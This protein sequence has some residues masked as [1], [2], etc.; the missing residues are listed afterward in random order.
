MTDDKVKN[1]EK[2]ICLPWKNKVN[3]V[4]LNTALISDGKRNHSEIIDIN[5]L[6]GLEVN[7][8]LPTIV[9]GHHDFNSIC[10]SHRKR[11]ISIFERL[12]VKAY[13]CGDTHKEDIKSIEKYD[14]ISE[15]IPCIICGKSAVQTGDA[16]SDV[17]IIEYTWEDDGYVYVRPYRWGEKY[18]FIKADDFIYDIDKDYRFLMSE[19][20]A[21]I[22]AGEGCAQAD[23]LGKKGLSVTNTYSDITEA[24]K[25]IAADIKEGGFFSFYGLRGATFIGTSEVNAIVK[26][27]K[28]NPKLQVKFLISY[29]FSEE[30]RHRLK[31]IPKFADSAS[32]E[33]KWRD[34]YKKVR[35][36]RQEYKAYDNVSVRFHDTS[37]IFRLMF[38]RKHL[39]LGYY[40]PGKDS[41]NTEIYQFDC[42]SPTYKTY[43]AFFDYQWRK[44]RHD[45]PGRIPS[46]YSFLQEKFSV[47]PSLVINVT[48]SCN[49]NCIYC[50]TGGENLQEF[51]E[52]ECLQ[53]DILR[54]LITAFKKHVIKDKGDPIL[55]ITGGEPLLGKANREKTA[56]ILNAAKDFKKIVL[57]TNAIYLREAYEEYQKDWD[58]V[59]SKLLLKISLDTLKP[60]RFCEITRTGERGKELFQTL[61]DNI[62][63]ISDKGFKIELNLVA[64]KNNLKCPEDLI[65]V[66]EFAQELGLV[67]VKILTVNDFGGNVKVEQGKEEQKYISGVLADVIR[68]MQEREYEEKEVYLN[69]DKGIQMRRFIAVSERDK[70]CTL[71]IVD[72]HNSSSSI[73]PRR[74]FS[75]FCDSCKYFLTSEEVRKGNVQPCAT[76]MMSLTVR[77]D[78]VLSPCRL[79]QEKGRNIK[80]I[81]TSNQMEKIVNDSLKAF[82]N[83]FH[84]NL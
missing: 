14:V 80:S 4:L 42:D 82:D 55:R 1:P 63:F 10:E 43:F 20:S 84:M 12:N 29:P 27:L 15:R 45:I 72:H 21:A 56:V 65:E 66:F 25:D 68:R 76:G 48:S 79:R 60:D 49:M 3:I 81:R 61:M 37:L 16:Y 36:L 6:S 44:A 77:A 41:V 62:R 8:E 40:E 30:I 47:R 31:N 46:K 69:D 28:G 19:A 18:N 71:T 51:K 17:G 58:A 38:T 22:P 7:K 33:E 83:C 32:C 74:T 39:Y 2:I 24:H 64:T 54:K 34:T 11:M 53:G 52:E 59:R 67:G 50:P 23:E 57:C 70:E 26:E 78:G 13:L 9:L 5:T 35:D 73:T 75:S